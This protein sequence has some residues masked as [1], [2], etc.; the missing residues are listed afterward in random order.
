MESRLR[1]D[2]PAAP[3]GTRE[4]GIKKVDNVLRTSEG[5]SYTNPP[6]GGL[7]RA[8]GLAGGLGPGLLEKGSQE[9][10]RKREPKGC[11]GEE[12]SLESRKRN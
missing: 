3:E 5:V 7:K 4:E 8:S 1:R 11:K 9:T 2:N 12:T 6:V 10:R